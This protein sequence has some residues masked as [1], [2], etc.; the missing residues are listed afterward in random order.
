MKKTIY[1]RKREGKTNYK[2]RLILLLSKKPRLVI[3]KSI[4]NLTIQIIR[5]SEDGDKIITAANSSELQKFGYNLNT[6]NIP[7]AY[8]TG[9]LIGKKAKDKKIGEV[10]VD[11]GLN[12][13]TKGSKIFAAVKGAVDSGLKI[14]HT[15][16]MFP[17]ESAIKGEKIQSYLIKLKDSK[18]IQ[19]KKY[20][21]AK[22]EIMKEIEKV[23]SAIMK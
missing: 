17:E 22:K 3:R 10:I 7:A 13:P 23:K 16:N 1:R 4:N 6:G 2:K 20:K 5:Y 9:L 19:F 14:P 12:T 18:S 15:P 8:L 11:I 21:S